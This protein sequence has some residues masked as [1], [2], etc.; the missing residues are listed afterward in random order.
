MIVFHAVKYYLPINELA[1]S[2]PRSEPK[3][4]R[5]ASR[6]LSAG[7]AGGFHTTP[8]VDEHARKVEQ[9]SVKLDCPLTEESKSTA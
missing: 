6:P 1:S 8:R 4:E 7:L 5:G 9:N 3:S 2:F